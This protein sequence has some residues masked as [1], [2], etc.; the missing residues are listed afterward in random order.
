MILSFKYLSFYLFIDRMFLSYFIFEF[1]SFS[2]ILI[3][4]SELFVIGV[5]ILFLFGIYLFLNQF[6]YNQYYSGLF[7]FFFIIFTISILI[8]KCIKQYILKQ[9][10]L[11]SFEKIQIKQLNKILQRNY[12]IIS[13]ILGSS[14]I[15]T[16]ERVG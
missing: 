8:V 15:P 11:F 1:Y 12:F 7:S 4:N 2:K 5:C 14:C 6:F 13:C 9:L 3:F 10:I 16:P